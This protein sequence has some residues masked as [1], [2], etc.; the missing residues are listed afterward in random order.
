MYL[1]Q[2]IS[3]EKQQAI[4]D[5][6]KLKRA[7]K[8]Y[9]EQVE[10][11]Q[12]AEMEISKP[13]MISFDGKKD[14]TLI[15]E[16]DANGK[17]KVVLK[18]EEHVSI[19]SEPGSKYLT[20]LSPGSKGVDIAQAIHKDLQEKNLLQSVK[21]IGADSTAVNTG[22]Q[23]GAISLLEQL[24]GERV[25][26]A[27]CQLHLN[28]LPLRHVFQDIDGKTDS[29]NTFKGP[30]GK[31]LPNVENFSLRST[32]QPIGSEL[33]DQ[34]ITLPECIV[35]DLSSD[36]KMMYFAWKSV[37]EG[38]LN[39]D[40]LSLTPGPL[41]HAR[42]LTLALRV[43]LLWMSDC[44]L[45][46]IDMSNLQ[47]IVHFVVTNYCPMWFSVKKMGKLKDGSKHLFSQVTALKHLKGQVLESARENVQRNSYYAH[48]ELL[49]TTML[50]DQDPDIRNQGVDKLLV[51]QAGSDI[52]DKEK[53]PFKVP[54]INLHC[55]SY[56]DLIDWDKESIT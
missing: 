38:T 46:D 31:L 14:D 49:L 47:K 39:I 42:W 9:E 15:T 41:S 10:K 48:S 54:K 45:E 12:K 37:L 2:V 52:G 24:K 5:R 3:S 16:V 13:K 28:E 56:V 4:I 40:L 25:L 35:S 53:R 17:N 1:F 6:M 55:N 19:M 51:L 27:I 7:I 50:A 20:H 11:E 21:I 30:V 33:K 18:K 32:F 34:T 44:K 26:W 23:N 22:W 29:R 36:Q 43:L 8:R